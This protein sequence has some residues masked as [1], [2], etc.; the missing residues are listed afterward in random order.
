MRAR[1]LKFKGPRAGVLGWTLLHF[2]L[3]HEPQPDEER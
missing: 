1:S 3:P 2:T